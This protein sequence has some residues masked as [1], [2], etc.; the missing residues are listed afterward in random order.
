MGNFIRKFALILCLI[1]KF[2]GTCKLATSCGDSDDDG[3][4][5]IC[6]KSVYLA[7]F[8]KKHYKGFADYT[9]GGDD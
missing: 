5:K 2:T 8:C 9:Y 7:G 4:C 3:G 1:L 6:G